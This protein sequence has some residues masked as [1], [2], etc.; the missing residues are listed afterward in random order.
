MVISGV[1]SVLFGVVLVFLPGTGL[2]ALVWV[3]GIYAIALGI[4]FIAYS[5]RL[6]MRE[7]RRSESSRVI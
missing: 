1:F 7:L 2:A 6:R 5:Y 3:I 4:A